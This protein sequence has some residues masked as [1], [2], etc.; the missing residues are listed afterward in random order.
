MQINT[1]DLLAV[2]LSSTRTS[3]AVVDVD[4]PSEHRQLGDCHGEARPRLF[5][6]SSDA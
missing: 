6:A 4:N 5:I 1:D 2:I 3:I